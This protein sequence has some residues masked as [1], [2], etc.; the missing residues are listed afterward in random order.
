LEP[1]E[2]V[3]RPRDQ[4][5]WRE[6]FDLYWR[7]IYG[8]ATKSGLADAE[9][10]DAVQ[11]TIISVARSMPD[12]EAEPQAGSFRGFL[13]TIT[14][15]RIADQF[16]KRPPGQ[17]ASVRRSDETA[18]T[19]TLERIADPASLD[20]DAVWN[21]EWEKNLM[22][23]AMER[24]KRQVALKQV[25]ILCLVVAKF[26]MPGQAR[27]NRRPLHTRAVLSALPT[28]HRSMTPTLHLRAF[29]TTNCCG[30]SAAEATA[31]CGWRGTS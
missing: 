8:V 29:P 24:V 15:R 25:Q 12:F 3:E 13:L 18:R 6:F 2:S 5:S 1:V 21:Q 27:S 31:K 26:V 17:K 7:L 20:L 22:D 28:L 16:R 11:E 19:S 10:Q 23:A 9:A 14:R 4:Q 30:A